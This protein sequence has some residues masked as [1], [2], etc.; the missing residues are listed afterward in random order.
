VKL[1][2]LSLL[3]VALFSLEAPDHATGQQLVQR[4]FDQLFA[5]DDPGELFEFDLAFN[6]QTPTVAL[7][8]GFFHNLAIDETG[9]RFALYWLKPDGEWDSSP[10]QGFVRLA[11]YGQ[12]PIDFEQQI[13]FTPSKVLLHV[14]GGGPADHFQFQGDFTIKQVPEPNSSVLLVAPALLSL[15]C[16]RL[17]S[18]GSRKA[19]V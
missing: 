18:K 19:D 15:T 14:E 11:S 2:C 6:L 9:V 1:R 16:R 5:G 4:S 7:F 17:R 10:E 12:L 8:D 3:A 13:G